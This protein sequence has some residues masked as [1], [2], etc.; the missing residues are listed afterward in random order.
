MV[1]KIIMFRGYGD[2]GLCLGVR[3]YRGI[4]YMNYRVYKK[5]RF[6]S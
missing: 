6:F 4:N 3:S 2:G 1:S 5:H